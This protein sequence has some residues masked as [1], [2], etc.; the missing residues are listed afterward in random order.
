MQVVG[1]A[2]GGA[3][4]GPLRNRDFRAL[5]AAHV[6][7]V[8]GDGLV[9]VALAFAVL[10]LTHSASQ[11]GFVL[12]ARLVPMVLFYVAGGVWGDRLPRHRVMVGAQLLSFVAQT[13]TGAL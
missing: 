5:Y 13:T 7:S 6:V 9:G 8:V 10:D 4:F 12:L 1:G 2:L 3:W 11:L